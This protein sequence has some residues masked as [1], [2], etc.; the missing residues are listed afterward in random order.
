MQSKETLEVQAG[1]S[2]TMR[3]RKYVM[4]ALHGKIREKKK[5]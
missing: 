4:C 5:N 2:E 1:V 3:E